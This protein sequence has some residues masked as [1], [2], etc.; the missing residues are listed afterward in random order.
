MPVWGRLRAVVDII[1]QHHYF[2]PIPHRALVEVCL[3]PPVFI[4]CEGFCDL[5]PVD[6]SARRSKAPASHSNDPVIY[7][8]T[9][10][11][12]RLTCRKRTHAMERIWSKS[13]VSIYYVNVDFGHALAVRGRS[14]MNRLPL[15]PIRIL[16]LVACALD[17]GNDPIRVPGNDCTAILF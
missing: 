7:L 3:G 1:P 13:E 14:C 6:T 17:R 9:L 8:S 4:K 16:K 10:S 11:D 12:R 5:H 15:R 2:A